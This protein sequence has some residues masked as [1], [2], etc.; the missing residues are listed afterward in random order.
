MALA[1]HEFGTHKPGL[2][3]IAKISNKVLPKRNVED[4]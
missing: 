2:D 3:K 1:K 4:V